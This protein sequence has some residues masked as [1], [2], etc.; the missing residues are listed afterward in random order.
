MTTTPMLGINWERELIQELEEEM[1][2][3]Q[4]STL[5]IKHNSIDKWIQKALKIEC[6][7]G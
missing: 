3:K 5:L 4:E 6:G 7:L 2:L 1:R